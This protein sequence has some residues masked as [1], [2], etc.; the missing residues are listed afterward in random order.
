MRSRHRRATARGRWTG[1][2]NAIAVSGR[3]ATKNA[4]ARGDR[5]VRAEDPGR[6]RA[7]DLDP[8]AGQAAINRAVELTAVCGYLPGVVFDTYR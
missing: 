3:P 8:A 5:A 4:G 1:C 7:A 6:G 2:L